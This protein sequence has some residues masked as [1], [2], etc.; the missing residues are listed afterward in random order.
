ELEAIVYAF[1][2]WPNVRLNVVSDSLY[3]VGVV[4][5]IEDA[6]LKDVANRRLND[7]FCQLRAAIQQRNQPYAIIHIRSHQWSDGLGEG[8]AR[9]DRLVSLFVPMNEFTKA[10]DAHATFHQNARGLYRHFKISMDEARSIV[11]ACPQCNQQG[12]GLGLG[13]NPWGLG[14]NE[15]WQMDVTHVPEFGRLK[16]V[17]VTID[18]YSHFI[19]AT[20]QSG[21]KALQVI[22]HLTMCFAVMGVP[23]H[24]KTDNGPAYVSKKVA[25]FFQQWGIKHTTGIP[26]LP[27]GQAI[28]ER[29]N[30]TL[31]NYL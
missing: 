17:H 8:N 27:T 15:K 5:R 22:W 25:R 4:Q 23:E 3:A 1:S 13:I 6:H 12:L 24:I 19:W 14:P 7:L 20:A 16:Y 31:K 11:K 10:R 28:V 9:A 2:Q 18:T 30:Q 21:E 26:H 29:A